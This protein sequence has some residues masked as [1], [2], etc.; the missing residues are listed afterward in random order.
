MI[1]ADD[2]NALVMRELMIEIGA[3]KDVADQ[4]ISEAAA[5]PNTSQGGY[6]C[7]GSRPAF[8]PDDP[9]ECR[10]PP[11][12][13]P[14]GDPRL[15]ECSRYFGDAIAKYIAEGRRAGAPPDEIAKVEAF[16]TRIPDACRR[17]HAAALSAAPAASR[18]ASDGGGGLLVVAA[19]ALGAF[20]VLR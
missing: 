20:V 5:D 4:V 19:L 15:P 7:K 11:L 3:P 12:P 2:F 16:A 9:A 10:R 18:S 1:K 13:W 17:A 14:D 8:N 6:I